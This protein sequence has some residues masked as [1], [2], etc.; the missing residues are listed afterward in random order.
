M[1]LALRVYLRLELGD[2]CVDVCMCEFIYWECPLASPVRIIKYRLRMFYMDANMC[3][4]MNM[5][6]FLPRPNASYTITCMSFVVYIYRICVSMSVAYATLAL[7]CRLTRALQKCKQLII[8]EMHSHMFAGAI[9]VSTR[10]GA[11]SYGRNC[12][13]HC[14][15]CACVWPW[16]GRRSTPGDRN[17][18]GWWACG[19]ARYGGIVL[20]PIRH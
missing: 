15:R 3:M 18:G 7:I 11:R 16:L 19:S 17:R 5:C 6:I 12:P 14:C 4:H 20:R 13:R 1:S 9:P 10:A 8:Y 2:A